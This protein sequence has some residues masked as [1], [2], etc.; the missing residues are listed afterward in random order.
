[1]S[2]K[3]RVDVVYLGEGSPH[4]FGKDIQSRFVT[5]RIAQVTRMLR[6]GDDPGRIWL[7]PEVLLEV[8]RRQNKQSA[9]N[10]CSRRYFPPEYFMQDSAILNN[11]YIDDMSWRTDEVVFEQSGSREIDLNKIMIFGEC[12]PHSQYRDRFMLS[13][14]T[15]GHRACHIDVEQR[16]WTLSVT[17]RDNGTVFELESLTHNYRYGTSVTPSIRFNDDYYDDG[18]HGRELRKNKVLVREYMGCH[19]E[20]RM[21]DLYLNMSRYFMDER[22]DQIRIPRVFDLNG[23][24]GSAFGSQL[25]EDPS[26]ALPEDDLWKR[27]SLMKVSGIEWHL[28]EGCLTAD[29]VEKGWSNLDKPQRMCLYEILNPT[30]RLK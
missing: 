6:E 24:Q 19:I 22:T 3:E 26:S 29:E 27:I 30:W 23:F 10:R 17:Y 5:H 25:L 21:D 1:M 2:Q 13:V 12:D 20:M 11:P 8:V 16:G 18:R 7:Y 14:T 4:S 9:N 28:N 15:Y